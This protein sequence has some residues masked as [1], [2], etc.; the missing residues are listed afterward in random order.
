MDRGEQRSATHPLFGIQLRQENIR[1]RQVKLLSLTGAM[2][3]KD[4][5]FSPMPVI[6]H[7]GKNGGGIKTGK[8]H[9]IDRTVHPH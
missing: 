3:G 9:E 7:G 5:K 1:V 4:R 6:Q 2:K 8:A